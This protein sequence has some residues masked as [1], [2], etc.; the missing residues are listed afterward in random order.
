MI[1]FT[2]V[3]A[4]VI[5][6]AASIA[7]FLFIGAGGKGA[8]RWASRLL[9]VAAVFHVAFLFGEADS[10]PQLGDIR[11]MLTVASLRP[12]SV[13]VASRWKLKEPPSVPLASVAVRVPVPRAS[14]AV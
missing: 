14:A 7:Y 6:A 4:S 1:Y 12:R 13:P 10:H 5:Y 3:T 9:L 2:F 8:E 11:Q